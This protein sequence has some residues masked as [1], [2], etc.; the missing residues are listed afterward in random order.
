MD[1]ILEILAQRPHLT[2]GESNP[3]NLTEYAGAIEKWLQI[4]KSGPAGYIKTVMERFGLSSHFAADPGAETDRG[5]F[6]T[7]NYGEDGSVNLSPSIAS[8]LEHA[9]TVISFG[10]DTNGQKYLKSYL[11]DVKPLVDRP[12]GDEGTVVVYHYH[13]SPKMRAAFFGNLMRDHYYFPDEALRFAEV[14]AMTPDQPKTYIGHS[15]AG[16]FDRMKKNALSHMSLDRGVDLQQNTHSLVFGTF[17]VWGHGDRS[18]ERKRTHYSEV[19][20]AASMFVIATEDLMP[21]TPDYAKKAILDAA[22]QGIDDPTKLYTAYHHPANRNKVLIILS[23]GVVPA[24]ANGKANFAGHG[25]AHYVEALGIDL[26]QR[27]QTDNL[28]LNPRMLGLRSAV[29]AILNHDIAKSGV[30][31]SEMVG[32]TPLDRAQLMGL[33]VGNEHYIAAGLA[34]LLRESDAWKD[35]G[36]SGHPFTGGKKTR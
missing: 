36:F 1:G 35:A 8:E 30:T 15:Y 13:T 32:A 3:G 18:K 19:Q 17:P 10:I 9:R 31:L 12:A 14:F 20:S 29:T 7:V 4:G 28:T 22:K 11:K 25:L 27:L 23:P 26:S 16:L 5:Q 2:P 34:A 24:K 33:K 6:F 21:Y